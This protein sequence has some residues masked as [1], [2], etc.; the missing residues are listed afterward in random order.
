MADPAG[1]T[2]VAVTSAA[3]S[4]V[5]FLLLRDLVR[6][7]RGWES[8]MHN[9]R[10]V[11]ALWRLDPEPPPSRLRVEP[12]WWEE[13][14]WVSPSANAPPGRHRAAENRVTQPH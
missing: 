11:R 3:M 8:R 14:I 5:A 4:A 12:P 7:I 13:V 1:I 6:R 9:R 2:F 10:W